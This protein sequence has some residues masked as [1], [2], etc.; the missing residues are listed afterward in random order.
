MD[1]TSS[2]NGTTDQS[3]PSWRNDFLVNLLKNSIVNVKFLKKDGTER[4][5]RCT[6]NNQYLPEQTTAGSARKE[7]PDV[8]AVY[9]LDKDDWRSFRWDSIIG[10]S[11]VK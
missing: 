1:M 2:Q 7:N 5:M 8:L 11:E 10:F 3:N 9:D 6:L 4:D